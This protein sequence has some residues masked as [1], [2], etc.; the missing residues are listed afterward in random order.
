MSEAVVLLW[1][2]NGL[3]SPRR[4]PNG[5]LQSSPFLPL[6][7]AWKGVW[8]G[9]EWPWLRGKGTRGALPSPHPT[10]QRMCSP[11]QIPFLLAAL[12]TSRVIAG[13]VCPQ[14]LRGPG[15]W[16][17]LAVRSESEMA[18]GLQEG[19]KRGSPGQPVPSGHCGLCTHWSGAQPPPSPQRQNAG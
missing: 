13:A 19:C 14:L 12:L 11:A 5:C 2:D 3:L 6:S 1:P 4:R 8:M 10:E 7:R 9:I 16:P 15:C 18:L 17:P